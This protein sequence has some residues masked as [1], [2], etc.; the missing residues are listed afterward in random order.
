MSRCPLTILWMA[1]CPWMPPAE[2]S[3]AVKGCPGDSDACR[4]CLTGL[5]GGMFSFAIPQTFLFLFWPR[6]PHGYT[7]EEHRV[8][9]LLVS[10]LYYSNKAALGCR[11]RQKF[12]PN[13]N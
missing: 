12:V 2:M 11:L 6:G 7:L 8:I 4:W 1:G 10:F 5:Q 13:N 9:L 3:A